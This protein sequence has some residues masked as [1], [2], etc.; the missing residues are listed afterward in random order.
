MSGQAQPPG[1]PGL[2]VAKSE[3]LSQDFVEYISTPEYTKRGAKGGFHLQLQIHIKGPAGQTKKQ[4]D[5]IASD[6]LRGGGVPAGFEV[7]AFEWNGKKAKTSMER[8][9]ARRN[10]SRIPFTF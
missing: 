8:R 9:V 1:P 5:E 2:V 4:L 7:G 6:W 3:G 10:F